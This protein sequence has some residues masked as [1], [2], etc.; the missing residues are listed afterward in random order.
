M[1]EQMQLHSS[2]HSQMPPLQLQSARIRHSSRRNSN[3]L[4]NSNAAMAA[5]A[6]VDFYSQPGY[7][8]PNGYRETLRHQIGSAIQIEAPKTLPKPRSRK[9]KTSIFY[10]YCSF[11]VTY[12]QLHVSKLPFK[13]IFH[14]FGA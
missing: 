8:D 7:L 12:R 5:V 13:E 11:T 6:T 2:K 10:H 1:S 9:C 14:A 3:D 4:I